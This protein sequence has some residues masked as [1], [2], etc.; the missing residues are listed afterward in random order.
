MST[1]RKQRSKYDMWLERFQKL[2][3]N[4]LETVTTKKTGLQEV[5]SAPQ[6]HEVT[7]STA[8]PDALKGIQFEY[9]G[10]HKKR[11]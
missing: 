1:S 2:P 7:R 3:L 10:S 5:N 4:R 6:S 9:L 11:K 8:C